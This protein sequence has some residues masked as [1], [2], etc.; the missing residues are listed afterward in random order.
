MVNGIRTIYSRG[1]NKEFGSRFR[2][3]SRVRQKTPEGGQKMHRPKG[4]E[5]NYKDE[6]NI[7]NTLSNKDV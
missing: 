4:C 6:S 5:Y 3:G 2:V 7:P 1:L